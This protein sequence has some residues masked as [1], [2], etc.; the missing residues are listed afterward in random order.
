MGTVRPVLPKEAASA[1]KSEGYILL[2]MRPEWE[3]EGARVSRPLHMPLFVEDMD[4]GPLTLLTR[5]VHFRYIGLWTGQNFT[6]INPDFVR[7]R[8]VKVKV[9]DKESKPLVACG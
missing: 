1:M 4:N 2:D 8:Q 5:W 9:P 3:R 7:L 6:M